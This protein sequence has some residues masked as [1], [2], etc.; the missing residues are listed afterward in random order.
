MPPEG[1]EAFL[2]GHTLVALAT[3][4]PSGEPHLAPTDLIYMEGR[5]FIGQSRGAA[6]LRD[7]RRLPRVS[8]LMAQGWRRHLLLEG[9]ARP[10][11]PNEP[12]A[13]MVQAEEQRRLGFSS[14]VIV[15]VLPRKMFAWSSA[16]AGRQGA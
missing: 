4:G 13:A 8:L 1:V 12:A 3:V 11:A 16:D 5:F 15:E 2:K 7:L 6:S 10:L 9:E 14:Q